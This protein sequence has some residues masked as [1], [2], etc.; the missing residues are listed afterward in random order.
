MRG[1]QLDENSVTV[2]LRQISQ[3]DQE[4][5]RQL[6]D[7]Y[8][9]ALQ[10]LIRNRYPKAFNAA[11]DEEDLVQSVFQAL[12]TGAAAR[13]WDSVQDRSELWW[14]LL[15]ITRRKAISRQVYNLRLKRGGNTVAFSELET[16]AQDSSQNRPLDIEGDSAPAEL[17]LMLQE[18]RERL[19]HRLRD[20]VLRSIAV[21]KL[22]GYTHEEIAAKLGVTPRTIIRKLCLIREDWSEELKL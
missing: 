14:L 13:Q 4:A 6:W 2:W 15:A 17:I 12:W 9:A 1:G 22:D 11:A 8:S 21:W 20:D 19:L 7:R 10:R 16:A 18:E 5:A 3:G